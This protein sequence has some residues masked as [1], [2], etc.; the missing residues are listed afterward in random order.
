MWS[1]AVVA[2]RH[3]SRRAGVCGSKLFTTVSTSRGNWPRSAHGSFLTIA[4]SI[5][6]AAEEL[7]GIDWIKDTR[8]I[9]SQQHVG[10][11]QYGCGSEQCPYESQ[12]QCTLKTAWDPGHQ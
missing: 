1:T 8:N 2:L 6:T 11:E 3:A 4:P 9:E 10:Y 12:H 5:M 7:L